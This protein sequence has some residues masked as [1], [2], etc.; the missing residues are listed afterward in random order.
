[1]L[2][3][4]LAVAY[5]EEKNAA[6]YRS[7]VQDL[8]NL[9]KEELFELA[10]G[11]G[12]L[13]SICGDSE[14]WLEKFEETP[15]HEQAL[16]LEQE[17]LEH[18]IAKE[19][20]RLAKAE[21]EDSGREERDDEWRRSDAIRLKKRILDLSLNKSKLQGSAGEEGEEEGDEEE[22][23]EGLQ[24]P[25]LET[26]EDEEAED[27][28]E[29]EAPEDMKAAAAKL[30][31]GEEASKPSLGK[32]LAGGA[33]LGAGLGGLALGLKHRAGARKA[34]QAALAGKIPGAGEQVAKLRENAGRL[35]FKGDKRV[36]D[37]AGRIG[38]GAGAVGGGVV[39]AGAGLGAAGAYHGLTKDS[40]ARMRSKLAAEET[41][42]ELPQKSQKPKRL[43]FREKAWG[44]NPELAGML[45][46]GAGGALLGG[47]AG[48]AGG[49]PLGAALGMAGGSLAGHLA[50]DPQKRTHLRQERIKSQGAGLGVMDAEQELQQRIKK[51][52]GEDPEETA[53]E[54]GEDVAV[55]RAA[56]G[57]P[58]G[59]LGGGAAGLGLG[60]L[61]GRAL[62]GR[63]GQSVGA[64]LGA[65][66]GVLGGGT[67]G[68]QAG[69]ATGYAHGEDMAEKL[70][71]KG[72]M[73]P[74]QASISKEAIGGAVVAGLK[75]AGKFLGSSAKAIGS[76]GK[77]RGLKG[78]AETAKM[79]G[80]EG[81]A[82]AGRFAKKNPG[83]ALAI[84]GGGLGATALGA[85][86][87]GRATA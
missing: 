26:D 31:E 25:D 19:Q 46:G 71:A 73:A 29:E 34:I 60:A 35:G 84:G 68:Y 32:R 49:V 10:E 78:A 1:M 77:A 81:A 41:A 59:A 7:F 9:P 14:E 23:Q 36:V 62:G 40:A 11:R 61:A 76:A 50:Q 13:A 38:G 44:T 2:D 63:L 66:G 65:A 86:A 74:K 67:L 70:R 75:G 27:E 12:K 21:E 79:V 18:E 17:E 8:T 33:A 48:G 28:G 43:S 24:D 15:F 3:K 4:F 51:A 82:S 85:G 72:L 69:K 80:R 87:L 64:G 45:G 55:N 30:A 58:L 57:I 53:D 16:A 54:Y 37:L 6:D 47:A 42:E 39:G 5:E 83:A 52:P 22:E 56:M 20:K